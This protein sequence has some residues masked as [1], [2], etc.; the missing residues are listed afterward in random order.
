ML[1]TTARGEVMLA[2]LEKLASPA[3]TP[4]SMAGWF[5]DKQQ[6]WYRKV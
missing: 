4:F 1:S 5:L 3:S 2:T 6:F